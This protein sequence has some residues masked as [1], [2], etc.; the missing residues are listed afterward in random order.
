MTSDP[1][2]G[3]P[4]WSRVY[5]C[6]AA[7]FQRCCSAASPPVAHLCLCRDQRPRNPNITAILAINDS[8]QISA[9]NWLP[10][11]GYRLLWNVVN[12]AVDPEEEEEEKKEVKKSIWNSQGVIDSGGRRV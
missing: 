8:L 3:C 9:A 1:P 5:S 7:G 11:R 10:G 2:P 6:I 12:G 4:L